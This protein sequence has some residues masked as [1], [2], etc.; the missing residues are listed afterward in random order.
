MTAALDDHPKSLILLENEEQVKDYL[1]RCNEVKGT[2]QI[3]ALSP[4]A[5]YELDKRNLPYRIPEEYCDPKELYQLGIDNY[6]RVED[7][8]GII[9]KKIQE[10]I[11]LAK[12]AGLMPALFNLFFFKIVYD[13]ITIRL[14]QLSKLIETE[15]PT[16]IF[17]YDTK[18]YPFGI[19]ETAP[20]LFFDNRESIYAHLLA[21]NGWN[22]PVVMLP[23][24]SRL[25]GQA[26]Q[27]ENP[28]NILSGM[29]KRIAGWLEKHPNLS[30]YVDSDLIYFL[31]AVKRDGWHGLSSEIKS[32]LKNTPVLLVGAG[33]NWDDCKER[34][35]SDGIGPMLRIQDDLKYWIAQKTSAQVDPVALRMSWEELQAD[36]TFHK[37]LVWNGID[38]LPVLEERIRYVIEQLAPVC[39]SAYQ[40]SSQIIRDRGIKAILASTLSTCIGHTVS[41]AAQNARIPVITWQHG[42]YGAAPN[43][44]LTYND[45]MSSD[46][47]FTFGVG[48]VKQF[49][50]PAKRWGTSLL[51]IG[52]AL[53]DRSLK[54]AQSQNTTKL[55]PRKKNVLYTTTNYYQ[56]NYYVHLPPYFS[57]N[58][59]WRVQSAIL[60]VLSK[61]NDY[62][63]IVKCHPNP[64]YRE[65]PLNLYAQ[66]KGFRN[67]RFLKD[68]SFTE[69]LQMAEIIIIDWPSTTLLQALTTSKPIFVYTGHHDLDEETETL[70]KRRAYCFSDVDELKK[71]LDLFLVSKLDVE[72][73]LK[74][75]EFLKV[76]GTYL[77]DGR[78]CI[79]AANTLIKIIDRFE[80]N[81]IRK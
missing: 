15:K 31:L 2:K 59:F 42:A 58:R 66:E 33:Y 34:L 81:A 43:P 75:M 21:L 65:P 63:I 5:M 39:L 26:V 45:L 32:W 35:T 20:Y 38:F 77:G 9:D 29:K 1:D 14:F 79:R 48:V 53:L 80:D 52:S 7:I 72:V 68:E 47:Y 36:A 8:C 69:L 25:E 78:S 57:D 50:E 46:V 64:I 44:M 24:I 41:K 62:D 73:D 4:F 51:P 30:S 28:Q 18:E 74:D 17:I 76:Y 71:S 61:N 60:D 3:I 13:A 11:P 37:L 55:Q 6:Q 49:T 27:G 10:H 40:K 56:N 67:C 22:I 16:S 70:L 19:S 12:E 54:M 23:T